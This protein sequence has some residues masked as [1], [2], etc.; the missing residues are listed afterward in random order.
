MS[1]S[2]T[3]VS[4]IT[5]IRVEEPKKYKVILHNDDKTTV[6]FVVIV[7]RNIFFKSFD[8]AVEITRHVHLSGSA[9]VGIYTKEI[10]DEKV[11]ETTTLARANGFPLTTTHEEV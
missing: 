4:T 7:L 6:D 3:E 1:S 8:E 5:E 9:I 11:T 10:A 2:S